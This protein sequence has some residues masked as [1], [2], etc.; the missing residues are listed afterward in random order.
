V[1]PHNSS[2]PKEGPTLIGIS[3]DLLALVADQVGEHFSVQG[4]PAILWR[5]LV[6]ER[7]QRAKAR[8]E[9]SI[10][11]IVARFEVQNLGQPLVVTI[12]EEVNVNSPFEVEIIG[13]DVVPICLKGI[14]LLVFRDSER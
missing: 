10:P 3:A 1:Y 5:G 14:K 12:G 9:F 7:L 6:V 8:E 4:L 2:G 11:A 13:V